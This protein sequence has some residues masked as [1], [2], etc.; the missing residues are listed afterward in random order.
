MNIDIKTMNITINVMMLNNKRLTKLIYKQLDSFRFTPDLFKP[1]FD[2]QILGYVNNNS[3]GYELLVKK[4]GKLVRYDFPDLYFLR[5]AFDP[6]FSNE[7]FSA[8]TSKCFDF[9]Q[10]FLTKK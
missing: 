2:G 1:D 3:K 10:I 6:G 5:T 8:I 7:E 4:G 9:G